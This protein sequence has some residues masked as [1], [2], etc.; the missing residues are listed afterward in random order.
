MEYPA[1]EL[2]VVGLFSGPD[3][4]GSTTIM[5]QEARATAINAAELATHLEAGQL[6]MVG[7]P[8]RKMT[9][10]TFDRPSFLHIDPETE[11]GTGN[12]VSDVHSLKVNRVLPSGTL[13]LLVCTVDYRK[14][15][16]EF[17]FD[18]VFGPGFSID[19][20]YVDTKR[21]SIGAGADREIQRQEKAE[22]RRARRLLRGIVAPSD[23]RRE[24]RL[25]RNGLLREMAQ[26][27]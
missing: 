21:T 23:E 25:K 5:G 17:V 16:T 3:S 6:V 1:K 27:E 12:I 20:R 15:L 2:M 8:A 10:L 14:S 11:E 22:V 26:A 19:Y 4:T 24:A 18:R 7:E 9:D 13:E